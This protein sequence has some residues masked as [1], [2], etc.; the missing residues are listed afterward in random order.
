MPDE[1]LITTDANCR[2]L[3][4]AGHVA[5]KGAILLVELNGVEPST[6]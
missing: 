5:E 6:S 1:K 3:A 2:R 4:I